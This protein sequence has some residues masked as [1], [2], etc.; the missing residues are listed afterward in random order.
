MLAWKGLKYATQ[1]RFMNKIIS[2]LF[3]IMLFTST[4]KVFSQEIVNVEWV[5]C[6]IYNDSTYLKFENDT[7]FYR[8]VDDGIEEE[9][10]VSTYVIEEDTICLLYTSPSPRDRG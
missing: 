5:A 10:R 4:I 1:F 9:F 6:N 3:G 8:T 2:L 7:L